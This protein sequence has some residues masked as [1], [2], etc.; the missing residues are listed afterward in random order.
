MDDAG[1]RTLAAQR[2]R[3]LEL[4]GSSAQAGD[5]LGHGAVQPGGRAGARQRKHAAQLARHRTLA[6]A[7]R[8]QPVA[9]F[10]GDV[11]GGR[12]GPGQRERLRPQQARVVVDTADD[13]PIR[14]EVE[15]DGELAAPEAEAPGAEAHRAAKA[16]GLGHL[17]GLDRPEHAAAAGDELDRQHAI[18]RG[19]RSEVDV[20][21]ELDLRAGLECRGRGVHLQRQAGRGQAVRQRRRPLITEDSAGLSLARRQGGVLLRQARGPSEQMRRRVLVLRGTAAVRVADLTRFTPVGVLAAGDADPERAVGTR[22][23]VG[24]HLTGRA[25][26]SRF[27]RGRRHGSGIIGC[28]CISGRCIVIRRGRRILGHVIR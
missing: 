22:V 20:G 7:L 18:D 19:Q 5:R 2:E 16:A 11:A 8:R 24:V 23:A 25:T 26:R 6:P 14:A 12:P 9:Q 27:L 10:Q 4:H 21:H 1:Q 17:L 13:R 15:I 3:P 28:R